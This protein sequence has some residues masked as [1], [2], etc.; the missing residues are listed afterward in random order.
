MA[1]SLGSLS[2]CFLLLLYLPGMGYLPSAPQSLPSAFTILHS[3]QRLHV[4]KE[5]V[6]VSAQFQGGALGAC[7]DLQLPSH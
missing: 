5:R 3:W 1:Y 6:E 4:G 7:E 2:S